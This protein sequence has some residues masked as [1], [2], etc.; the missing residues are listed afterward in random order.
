L[1]TELLKHTPW[2]VDEMEDESE[3]QKETDG[4]MKRIDVWACI[5]VVYYCGGDVEKEI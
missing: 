5:T 3:R 1:L 4:E 2:D